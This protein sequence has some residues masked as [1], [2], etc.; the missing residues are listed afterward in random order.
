MYVNGLQVNW[1]WWGG[2]GGLQYR[3]LTESLIFRDLYDVL[4]DPFI[5]VL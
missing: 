5:Y 2:A 1:V 4:K 3:E